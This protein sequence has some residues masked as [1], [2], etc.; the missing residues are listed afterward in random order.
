MG[1]GKFDIVEFEP[2][3]VPDHVVIY[4]ETDLTLVRM[5]VDMKFPEFPVPMGV[6]KRVKQPT[7]DDRVHEQIESAKTKFK[8]DL[9]KLI[10]SGDTW[11]VK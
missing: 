6:I 5:I 11:E 2:E 10:S 1:Y 9:S 8:P 7:F 3:N 4:D